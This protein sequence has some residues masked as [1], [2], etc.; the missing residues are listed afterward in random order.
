MAK[1]EEMREDFRGRDIQREG[2]KRWNL[3]AVY[4]GV[5][6]EGLCCFPTMVY[7]IS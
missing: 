6:R 7:L 2:Q 3:R 5:L 1:I 4:H